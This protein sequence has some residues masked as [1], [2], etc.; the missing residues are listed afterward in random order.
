[1]ASSVA[2]TSGE[3]SGTSIKCSVVADMLRKELPSLKKVSVQSGRSQLL[4]ELLQINGVP[5]MAHD[6][7]TQ[8]HVAELVGVAGLATPP[9][10]HMSRAVWRA[11]VLGGYNRHDMRLALPVALESLEDQHGG[12]A[13][14]GS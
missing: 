13:E 9:V 2:E 5:H 6:L 12:V 7:P 10:Q 1:M 11:L 3:Q 4:G 14:A 8:G